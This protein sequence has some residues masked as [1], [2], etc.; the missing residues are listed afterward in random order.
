[1]YK[2]NCAHGYGWKGARRADRKVAVLSKAHP[3]S[4]HYHGNHQ[5]DGRRRQ[6]IVIG[7]LAQ[8]SAQVIIKTEVEALKLEA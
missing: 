7:K 2:W 3:A 4:H 6:P 1:M 5:Q 8:E